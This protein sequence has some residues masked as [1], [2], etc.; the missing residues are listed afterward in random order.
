MGLIVSCC[1]YSSGHEESGGALRRR[2][3]LFHPASARP[4][5]GPG[6][7]WLPRSRHTPASLL[8]ATLIHR[9]QCRGGPLRPPAQ[10][11][12]WFR[13]RV[14]SVHS[15]HSVHTVHSSCGASPC[16]PPPPFRPW[17]APATPSR[18]SSSPPAPQRCPGTI[19]TLP[20]VRACS[21]PR[22]RHHWR[23]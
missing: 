12:P 16:C 22:G 9:G 15:V 6:Y 2:L 23:R 7:M 3:F 8:P 5:V 4:S 19:G 13:R 10:G 14:H 21:S 11:S 18:C 20:N 17:T 1:P